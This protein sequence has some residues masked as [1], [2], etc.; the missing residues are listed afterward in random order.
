MNS[1]DVDE[2]AEKYTCEELENRILIQAYDYS[3]RVCNFL[4]DNSESFR[5]FTEKLQEM[6]E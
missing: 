1:I 4:K 6:K 5:Q 2:E 3:Q